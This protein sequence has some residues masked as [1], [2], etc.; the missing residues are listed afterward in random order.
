MWLLDL[1]ILKSA[2]QAGRLETQGKFDVAAQAQQ[3]SAERFFLPEGPQAFLLRPSTD[4]MRTTN[5]MSFTQI[6]LT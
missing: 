2:E 3:Q 1:P 6:W 4:W 5:I